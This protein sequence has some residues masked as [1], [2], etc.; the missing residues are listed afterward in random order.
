GNGQR[1]LVHALAGVT[2]I[3]NGNV[4]IEGR[5]LTGA[6][7]RA[8]HAA[9]VGVIPEDRQGW[10]LVLD[11]SVAENI[12]LAAVPAGKFSRRGLLAKRAIRDHARRLLEQY[13]VRPP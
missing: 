8:L 7:P 5:D 10:G 11:M 13:D 12:A 9:G 1:E 6:S 4:L 3:E 2:R